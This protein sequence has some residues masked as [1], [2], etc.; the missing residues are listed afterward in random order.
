MATR[1]DT[2]LNNITTRRILPALLGVVLLTILIA[3]CSGG[4]GGNPGS[5]PA[6]TYSGVTTQARLTD[7]NAIGFFA[8][9]WD[10]GSSL[11]D[12]SSVSK[13]AKTATTTTGSSSR[14]GGLVRIVRL[15]AAQRPALAQ[16]PAVPAK[17]VASMVPINETMQGVVSGTMTLSGSVDS[18]SGRGSVTITC[19]DFNDGDGYTHNGN[20]TM[21]IDSMDMTYG[22]PLDSTISFDR[23]AITDSGGT[24]DAVFSGSIRL[25]GQSS[26]TLTI[27]LDGRDNMAH[28]MFRF[29]DITVTSG[30]S[31]ASPPQPTESMSGRVYREAFGYVAVATTAPLIYAVSYAGS[32]THPSS[33]G[34]LVLEGAGA[35][36]AIITPQ[37]YG[38]RI[39]VDSD[40]DGLSNSVG[41]YFWGN[42]SGPSLTGLSVNPAAPQVPAG[43]P[44]QFIA[45]GDFSDHSTRDLTSLVTWT[46][47]DPMIAEISSREIGY[48]SCMEPGCATAVYLGTTPVTATLGDVS[49]GATIEVT[50]AVLTAM[51]VVQHDSSQPTSM[52]IGMSRQLDVIGN[53]S[54]NY[55]GDATTMVT[56]SSSDPDVA[57]VSNT[58][59]SQGL[60]TAIKS[61][62]A[63]I[64][65]SYGILTSSLSLTVTPW[66]LRNPGTS[67][68]LYRVIWSG[69]QFVALGA[70]G[71]VL[72]SPD[73]T[74]FQMSSSDTTEALYDTVWGGGRYVAVGAMGTVLTSSDG[75]TWTARSS[76][77]YDYLYGIAWTGSRFVAVGGQGGIITSPDGVT[78][79]RQTSGTSNALHGVV[80]TGGRLV[81]VGQY[82]TLLTSPDGAIWT[83]QNSNTLNH[84]GKIVWSGTQLVALSS[85]DPNGGYGAYEF[86]LHTSP[87]GVTWSNVSIGPNFIWAPADLAWCGGQFVTAGSDGF[88]FTSGDGAAWTQW[89][90]GTSSFLY[91]VGC[92]GSR[93]T[94]TGR[95]G[96]LLS[97]P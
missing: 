51:T 69:Q 10:G 6:V 50:P 43:L 79:T 3:G 34:P 76:G 89:L 86:P 55:R 27:N 8:L 23:W 97:Y 75:N 57:T 30:Y 59:G 14:L 87:D 26:T 5:N 48:S 15:A 94:V 53:F 16:A 39:D 58:A 83:P 44:Q 72:T 13:A 54:N 25:V 45:T 2:I 95:G 85:G 67:A 31:S 88:L 17:R 46:T 60:V 24:L 63:T 22:V 40:G 28:E 68:D 21:R 81:A 35:T 74:L 9:L 77:F 18:I 82:G 78:W 29:A 52:A 62:P 64:T 33:G 49:G 92:S 36:R 73:G 7:A 47:G 1:I 32:E 91:A 12:I 80:W 37:S 66:T 84:L 19:R 41:R 65:V 70:G 11:G 90:V 38:V 42:L 61:G 20:A 96:L 93:Y 71:T 4:G 56:W